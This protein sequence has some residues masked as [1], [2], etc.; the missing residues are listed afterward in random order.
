MVESWMHFDTPEAAR[1][2]Q[3]HVRGVVIL[4]RGDDLSRDDQCDANGTD[5]H[6]STKRLLIRRL[7]CDDASRYRAALNSLRKKK[8]P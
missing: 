5:G 8:V 2:P 6:D 1:E 7:A 3:K 4:S